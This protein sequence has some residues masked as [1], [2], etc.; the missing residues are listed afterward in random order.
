MAALFG[1]PPSTLPPSW[2]MFRD[3]F[4]ETVQSDALGV[5]DATRA[6]AQKLQK[7]IG[8]VVPP[9]FWYQAL[10][11]HLLPPRLRE[12]FQLPYGMREERSAKRALGLMRPVYRKLP[13]TIR[14]VGPYN[15]A[16]NR[17]RGGVP[18]LAVQ[19]SNRLW[20]GQPT[21]QTQPRT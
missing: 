14:F 12:E 4:D 20:I 21:L 18:G 10:T 1:I 7:G 6:F 15:E 19:M 17:L 8:L 16:A 13:A 11:I 9:P 3:Y 5:S 2:R